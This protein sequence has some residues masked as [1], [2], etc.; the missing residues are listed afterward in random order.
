MVAHMENRSIIFEDS[1]SQSDTIFL[2]DKNFVITGS[3]IARDLIPFCYNPNLALHTA[4][5]PHNLFFYL[6]PR[7]Y[8]SPSIKSIGDGMSQ[9]LWQFSNRPCNI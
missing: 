9:H 6:P 8:S 5:I 4:A 1:I 3:S 7:L 2:R